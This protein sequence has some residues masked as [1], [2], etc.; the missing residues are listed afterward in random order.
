MRA[1]IWSKYHC[2]Y[3]DQAKA[4]LHQKGIPFEEKK[5][6]IAM[7]CGRL[8]RKSRF[9]AVRSCSLRGSR[10]WTEGPERLR[11]DR[12]WRLRTGQARSSGRL[13]RMLRTSS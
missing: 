9:C 5:I 12:R 8:R 10:L 4:L 7:S 1:V 2:P 11:R 13:S 6:R 3:C